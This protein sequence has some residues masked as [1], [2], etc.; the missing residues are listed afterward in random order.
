MQASDG[1]VSMTETNWRTG[2]NVLVTDAHAM[3]SIAVIRSLGRAGYRV[4]ACSD[5]PGALGLRSSFVH[6]GLIS[7]ATSS[8]D[9]PKWL[10]RVIADNGI[11]GIIPSEGALIA[12]RRQFAEFSSL[13]PFDRDENVVYAGLSKFDLFE[14]LDG[15][16]LTKRLPPY[17]LVR[18]ATAPPPARALAELGTPVFLKADATHGSGDSSV[19]RCQ[20]GEAAAAEL[21]R[22]LTNHDRVLI[23][24]NVPGIGVGVFF[25][26]WNGRIL[27]FF[28]HRRVHEVPH[29]GGASS[30][31]AAWWNDAVFSDARQCIEALRWEGVGMLE[32]R[33][34]PSTGEFFLLEFNGRFWGSLH[35][36]LFA[37]VDFPRLL[38]DAFYGHEQSIDGF[39][40][41]TRC[42]WTFPKEVEYVWSCVK[43]HSLPV[44]KRLSV[45]AEFLW[46][47]VDPGVHSDLN[48]PGDRML[49]IREFARTI[50][51]VAARKVHA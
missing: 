1:R 26:R 5:R 21:D 51:R 36:A 30:Y 50:G 2:L 25:L 28:M 23:Q 49:Y 39:D 40:A 10:G 22:L 9:F 3:G 17:H 33:W 46:L 31:R 38:L 13:L 12:V 34:N 35:L 41:D 19:V 48:F 47:G 7:P 42:R 4:Y 16:K 37:G 18:R 14:L 11:T 43:D 44:T 6:A 20:T 24:G 45:V 15:L 8:D 29:T 32:Y 27:A